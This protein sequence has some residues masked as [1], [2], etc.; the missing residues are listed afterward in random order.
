MFAVLNEVSQKFSIKNE[1]IEK[2]D[3]DNRGKWT[4]H[5]SREQV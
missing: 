5:K 4:N 1:M 2:R 3:T